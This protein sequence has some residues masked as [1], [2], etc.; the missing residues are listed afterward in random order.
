M[1]HPV[2]TNS[3]THFLLVIT[4]FG[5]AISLAAIFAMGYALIGFGLNAASQQI[6]SVSQLAGM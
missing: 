2:Q 6:V 1:R 4:L 3:E 5:Y